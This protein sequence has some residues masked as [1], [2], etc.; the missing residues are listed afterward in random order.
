MVPLLW[1]WQDSVHCNQYWELYIVFVLYIVFLQ[2]GVL[3]PLPRTLREFLCPIGPCPALTH[4]HVESTRICNN[5]WGIWKMTHNT[6]ISLNPQLQI[7]PLIDITWL[8]CL[9]SVRLFFYYLCY[10]KFF[11][12]PPHLPTHIYIYQTYCT[13]ESRRYGLAW[14]QRLLN[15]LLK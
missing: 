5:N 14:A 8:S 13:F 6:F 11:R 12:W 1:V 2:Y 10:L 3:V 15:T 9:L 4:Q 7:N